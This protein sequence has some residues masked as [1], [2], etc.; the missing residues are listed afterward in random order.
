MFNK[1]ISKIA[2]DYHLTDSFTPNSVLINYFPAKLNN[3]SPPSTLPNHADDELEIEPGSCIFTYSVGETRTIT[4]SAVHSD[5]TK[6]HDA[7][8]NTL[9]VMTR[10]SQAWFRHQILDVDSCKERFSITLRHINVKNKRSVLIVGDSNTKEIKFGQGIGHVGETYPGTRIKAARIHQINPADCVE[11]ANVVLVCGTN[12]LRP[13]EIRLGEGETID[14]HIFN[15]FGVLK[16]KV[17]QISLLSKSKV[18]VMPVLPT[19]DPIMNQNIQKFNRL[20]YTTFLRSSLNISTPGVYSF[21]DRRGLL[22]SKLTRDGD[23]I[24]LGNVGLCRFVRLIKDCIYRR[25]R[26]ENESLGSKQQWNRSR[27][28]GGG[29]PRPP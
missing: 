1:L 7:E 18:F 22:D 28:P 4:F 6:S 14:T 15:L 10:R 12:D 3:K 5:E 13:D 11:H 24:H 29:F 17:E 20:V 19:R 27:I 16:S 2:S 26:M 8:D 21:L 9:Y 25:E 23:S